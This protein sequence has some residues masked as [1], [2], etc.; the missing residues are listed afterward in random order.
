MKEKYGEGKFETR[1]LQKN[2]SDNFLKFLVTKWGAIASEK[3]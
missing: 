3:N 2:F 1:L